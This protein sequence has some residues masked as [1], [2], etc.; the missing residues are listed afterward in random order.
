MG[1]S[2]FSL[3]LNVAPF[4]SETI[5]YVDDPRRETEVKLF[6]NLLLYVMLWIVLHFESLRRHLTIFRNVVYAPVWYNGVV[7]GFMWIGSALSIFIGSC[8]M[9]EEFHFPLIVYTEFATRTLLLIRLLRTMTKYGSRSTRTPAPK[10]RRRRK[11]L[12]VP[13]FGR[14]RQLV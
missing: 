3:A 6:C 10:V 2:M 14:R 4:L 7:P 12:G 13:W 9:I 5:F 11:K 1:R 8:L